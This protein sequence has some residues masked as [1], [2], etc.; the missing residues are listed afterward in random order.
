[1]DNRTCPH[2]KNP[3]CDPDDI[4][5]WNCGRELR[6]YCANPECPQLPLEKTAFGDVTLP[7]NYM[8]CPHCGSRSRFADLG[9]LQQIEF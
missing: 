9:F 6:N 5:C 2:C 3:G 1:M 4:F 8:Y 7:E